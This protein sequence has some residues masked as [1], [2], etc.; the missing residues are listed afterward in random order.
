MKIKQP[1]VRPILFLG[2][3]SSFSAFAG[4]FQKNV[5]FENEVL[6][7]VNNERSSKG[8]SPLRKSLILTKAAREHSLAMAR[9]NF[10]AH[11][12]PDT[13]KKPR[14]R[15]LAAGYPYYS[16]TGENIAAGWESP[17]AVV[18]AWMNSPGHKENI[19]RTNFKEI[20]IGY[21]YDTHDTSHVDKVTAGCERVHHPASPYRHYW[22]QTFGSVDTSASENTTAFSDG[23][24]G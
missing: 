22:T 24:E 17:S 6:L 18:T 21:I 2:L 4:D 19:L 1:I 12:N 13:K 23:F 3:L 16:M 7:L 15:I 14:N 10:F 8:L 5:A 11:C 20:G 9:D